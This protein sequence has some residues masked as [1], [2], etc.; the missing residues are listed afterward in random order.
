M[1]KNRQW[2]VDMLE[3]LISRLSPDGRRLLL[4][5]ARWLATVLDWLRGGGEDRRNRAFKRCPGLCL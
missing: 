5:F 2:L 3:A 4:W 1:K